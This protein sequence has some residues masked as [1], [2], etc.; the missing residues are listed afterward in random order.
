MTSTSLPGLALL[1]AL[2]SPLSAAPKV[3][4]AR[5]VLPILSDN[6]FHCHGPDPKTRQAG[7]RLDSRDGAFRKRKGRSLIVPGKPGHSQFIRRVTSKH[8]DEAMPP[9]DS[10]RT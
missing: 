4:F 3:D 6:C 7:L 8:A 9:P 5:D 10:H 2:A 1:V